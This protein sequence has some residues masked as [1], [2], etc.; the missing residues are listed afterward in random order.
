MMTALVET[1]S[2]VAYK[3]YFKVTYK[4]CEVTRDNK[5]H[6]PQRGYAPP[7][8]STPPSPYVLE[9]GQIPIR[10]RGSSVSIVSDYGLDTGRSGFDPWQGQKI[11][12][13][14]SVSRS[15]LRST[16]PRVQWVPGVFPRGKA[17]PGRDTDHH[18]HLVLRSMMSR[19][20]TYPKAPPC[21]VCFCRYQFM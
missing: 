3:K 1:S 13:P 20:C 12:P 21:L 18:P 9:S 4:V 7:H 5:N 17:R 19:S 8:H 10:S 15:A 11:F 14:S 6:M 2:L 16:Q